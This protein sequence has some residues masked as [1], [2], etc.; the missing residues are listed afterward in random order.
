MGTLQN[1]SDRRDDLFVV[2]GVWKRKDNRSR[3]PDRVGDGGGAL[4]PDIL[5]IAHPFRNKIETDYTVAVFGGACDSW[6]SP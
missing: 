3:P 4:S 1:A 6:R 5:Q 2:A